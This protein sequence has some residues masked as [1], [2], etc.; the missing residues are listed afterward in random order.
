MDWLDLLAVQGTFKTLLQHHSS[1][2]SILQHS[3]FFTVQLSYLYMTTGKSIALT[4]RA[5]V[6]KVLSLL[7]NILSSDMRVNVKVRTIYQKF[8]VKK[9]GRMYLKQAYFGEIRAKKSQPVSG[10]SYGGENKYSGPKREG[11]DRCAPFLRKV[12]K[13]CAAGIKEAEGKLWGLHGL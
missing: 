9:H 13:A 4:R 2:A 5:F 8:S 7:F 10:K 3:A 11:E 1:K 6:G 12:K